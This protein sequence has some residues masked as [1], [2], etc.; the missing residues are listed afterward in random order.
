VTTVGRRFP[1][2][3][4]KRLA[5]KP[6]VIMAI[7]GQALTYAELDDR[8]NQA[9]RMFAGLTGGP[10]RHVAFCVENRLELPWLQWG[11]HYAGLYYTFISTRLTGEEI[12][13][14]VED[15][16]AR[17]LVVSAQTAPTA[18]TELGDGVRVLSLDAA[19]EGAEELAGLMGGESESPLPDAVEGSDMLYSSGTTGRPKGIKPELTGEPLGSTL[20]IAD[21]GTAF[22]GMGEDSVYLSPAPYYHAAPCRWVQGFTGVGATAVIMERFDAEE[23]LRAIERYGVTHSQWVPTMFLRMLRLP[24]DVRARYDLSSHRVAIHA[25]APCP[26]EVKQA[27]IDWWG[28]ILYEYY[29]GTEGAG[30]CM[31]DTE[32][33][34]AHPG[35][36][37]KAIYG[38]PHVVDETGR[39]LPIGE[40]GLI[41]FSGGQRF[42]YHGDPEKTAAVYRG[43]MATL[44]DVGRLDEDGYL[45]LTDRQSNMIISGGVNIYPQEAENV[46]AGHPKVF[47]VAVIGVPNPEFGEEVLAVV[48][49]AQGVAG[50][51]EDAQELIAA[52][53][54]RLA[55]IKCPRRVEFRAALPREPNGKLLKRKL[56]E[57]YWAGRAS[58]LA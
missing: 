32:G 19:V 36:V 55:K 37:G 39:E 47:D 5:E 45:Y 29:S 28:P 7:S 38:E 42:E 22:F 35:S 10:R 40:E 16:S 57:E 53:I 6:A 46:L 31:C 43:E 33:W 34:R 14:I 49:P 4:R 54:A 48:Q 50:T 1:G 52:C 2:A 20:V 30:M 25:A 18:L 51:D 8:A 17:V 56:R 58:R 15:C 27:M 13:Y 9:A 24:D 12:A 44:G 11:A 23:A 3:F 21:L 26:V 41:Y